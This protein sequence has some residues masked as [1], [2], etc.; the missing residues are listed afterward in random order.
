MFA[1][2][3]HPNQSL[4]GELLFEKGA[5][6]QCMLTKQGHEELEAQLERWQTEGIILQE[7]LEKGDRV[8]LAQKHIPLRSP[9]CEAAFATWAKRHHFALVELN[10]LQVEVYQQLSRH[11]FTQEEQYALVHSIRSTP[12]GDMPMWKTFF[13]E[14]DGLAQPKPTKK[15]IAL[16][17][18]K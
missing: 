12:A 7:W 11:P 3:F 5:F 17:K 1:L 18:K 2:L 4:L 13:Q 16:T 9:E 6:R 14:L 10:R 8:A 15:K